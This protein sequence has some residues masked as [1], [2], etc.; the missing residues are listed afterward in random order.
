MNSEYK[1]SLYNSANI[2]GKQ[3]IPIDRYLIS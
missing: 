2:S 3:Q 1:L